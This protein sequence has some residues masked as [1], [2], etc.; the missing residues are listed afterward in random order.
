[1]AQRES[2]HHHARHSTIM[3][4]TNG[5]SKNGNG[6]GGGNGDGK[7][8]SGRSIERF[9]SFA[10]DAERCRWIAGN[11]YVA[12]VSDVLDGLG[13]RQQAMHQRLRPLDAENYTIVGRAKTFRWME[14]DYV[15]D[16]DPYG[17]EIE[18]MDSLKEGDVVVHSTDPSGTH[19]PWGEL[20]TTVAKRNGTVGCL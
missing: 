16:G 20:M 11:L 2:K 15:V 3:A 8:R 4:S 14:T 5:K 12:A 1:M 13:F 18:A 6:N 7:G 19:A 10:D 17:L 9:V